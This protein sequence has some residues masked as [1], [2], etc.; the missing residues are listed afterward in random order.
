MSPGTEE[1]A[2]LGRFEAEVIPALAAHR[3]DFILIS[4]GFDAHYEDSLGSLRLTPE[5]FGR[6]THMLRGA[7][8]ESCGGRIVS[9]LEGGYSLNALASSAVA[10]LGALAED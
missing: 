1:E 3:P 7:A 5:G 9:L 6:L 10:H 2:Y 4:A 8:D